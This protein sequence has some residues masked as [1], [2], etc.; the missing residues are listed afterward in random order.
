MLSAFVKRDRRDAVD[1]HPILSF[2][3]RD[4]IARRRVLFQT[5]CCWNF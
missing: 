3:S 4:A 2:E 5:H 1:S